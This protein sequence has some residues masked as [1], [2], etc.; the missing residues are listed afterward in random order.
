MVHDAATFNFSGGDLHYITAYDQSTV[1]ITGGF[2]GVN[3][4]QNATGNISG[5]A[6]VGAANI[7]GSGILNVYSGSIGQLIANGNS[8]V[9]LMGGT[10]TAYLGAELSATINVFGHDL[11]KTDTGG[12]YGYGQI[13]GFWQDD[14]SFTINLAGSGAYSVTNLIPE[15]ATFLL[16]GIGTLLLRKSRHRIQKSE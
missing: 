3:V 12:M 15:P 11:A 7:D 6:N 14:S 16:F 4:V 8:I 13:T 10:F 1:N 2:S 5:N 9:N